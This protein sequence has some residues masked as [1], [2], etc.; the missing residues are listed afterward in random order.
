MLV[1]KD[2]ERLKSCT[3][4]IY[5]CICICICICM[6]AKMRG[7][8]YYKVNTKMRKDENYIFKIK[9]FLESAMNDPSYMNLHSHMKWELIK[10][11][12]KSILGQQNSK[13]ALIKKM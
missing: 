1:S 6:Q 12:I 13:N 9:H 2:I 8:L 10:N 4:Y 5:M 11:E 7:R 3:L